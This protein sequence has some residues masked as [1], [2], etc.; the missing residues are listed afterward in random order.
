[1]LDELADKGLVEKIIDKPAKFMAVP[2]ADGLQ[3]LLKRRQEETE[4]LSKEAEWISKA[5]E[6]LPSMDE[7]T[8]E[9]RLIPQREPVDKMVHEMFVTA[10]TSIDLM[11]ETQEVIGLHE[12]H[13]EFKKAALKNGVQVREIS[14]KST[15]AQL[16]T[17]IINYAKTTPLYK[18]KMLD[19]P[20]TARLMIKDGKEVFFCTTLKLGTVPQ[21]FMWTDNPVLVQIIQQWYNC[22]WASANAG[23]EL[24]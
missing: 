5:V 10:K 24:K 4:K 20:A 8:G 3:E 9:F 7:G 17:S 23:S 16:P 2:L 19:S 15:D 12:K 13:N 18:I 22:V 6:T 21:Q 14:C 1:L 11:N